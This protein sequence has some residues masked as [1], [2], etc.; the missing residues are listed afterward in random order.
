LPLTLHLPLKFLVTKSSHE[1]NFWADAC[2]VSAAKSNLFIWKNN[3]I[4]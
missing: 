2:A 3:L 1:Q 4:R